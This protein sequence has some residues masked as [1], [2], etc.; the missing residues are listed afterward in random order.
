VISKQGSVINRIGI[1]KI[2]M[3]SFLFWN[4]RNNPI[5]SIIANLALRHEVDVLMLAECNIA[6]ATLLLA[7]N[8]S[9]N[10][11]YYYIPTPNCK[12][13]KI[14]A[15]CPEKSISIIREEDKFTLRCLN[16]GKSTNIL[17]SVVHLPSKLYREN[18]D[19]IITGIYLSESIKSAEKMVGHSKTILVGDLNMNPYDKGIIMASAINGTM[20]QAIAQERFRRA[21]RKDYPFFYN[22]MWNF[23]GDFNSDPPGTYYYKQA[24]ESN[25]RWY[26]YDQVLIR[27][28]LLTYFSINDLKILTSDGYTNFLSENGIPRK[29]SISDHLPL[30]FRLNL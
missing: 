8:E 4:I 9:V 1:R 26:I 17:L 5:Q 12:R 19:Q 18:E 10:R 22:P 3:T 20:S 24:V 28:D 16:I 2:I 21:D 27:P 14:F 29:D 6:P 15:K 30:F 25:L 13:L 11:S 7:L 23:L